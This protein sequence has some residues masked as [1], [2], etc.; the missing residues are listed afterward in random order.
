MFVY[1][2]RTCESVRTEMSERWTLTLQILVALKLPATR[3]PR[4]ALAPAWRRVG[5]RRGRSVVV[6]SGVEETGRAGR[7]HAPPP[8][9]WGPSSEGRVS[10]WGGRGRRAV[11]VHVW[12]RSSHVHVWR[13]RRRRTQAHSHRPASTS[14]ATHVWIR[15]RPSHASP[16][17]SKSIGK[18]VAAS[19]SHVTRGS[20]AFH[21]HHHPTSTTNPTA[22]PATSATKLHST[23]PEFVV[24]RRL[25]LRGRFCG[26]HHF[27][28]LLHRLRFGI[29]LMR[30]RALLNNEP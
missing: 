25:L 30:L 10:R 19:S 8:R 20:E 23:T 4:P 1:S 14:T 9:M 3:G 11:P 24:R 26:R 12:W 15:P 18:P 29:H 22:H 7:H 28:R 16:H 6:T 21:H 17:G 2:K 27:C 13:R 5:Q